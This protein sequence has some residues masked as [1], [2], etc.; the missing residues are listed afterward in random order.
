MNEKEKY[1]RFLRTLEFYKRQNEKSGIEDNRPVTGNVGQK[2]LGFLTDPNGVLI[3]ISQAPKTADDLGP[4]TYTP[5]KPDTFTKNITIS[6]NSKRMEFINRRMKVGPGDYVYGEKHTKMT[7]KISGKPPSPPVKTMLSGNIGQREWATTSSMPLPKNRFPQF[8]FN[9]TGNTRVFASR[10]ERALFKMPKDGVNERLSNQTQF[11]PQINYDEEV[12]LSAVFRSE[13]PRYSDPI[14]PTPAPTAYNIASTFGSSRS[15][16]LD[17][18][19]GEVDITP[20]PTPPGPGY[21]DP[22]KPVPPRSVSAHQVYTPK[23]LLPPR[24]SKVKVE[25]FE[26]PPPGSYDAEII[27]ERIPIAIRRKDLGGLPDWNQLVKPTE[28]RPDPSKYDVSNPLK[29]KGGLITVVGHQGIV[30][31]RVLTEQNHRLEFSTPHSSLLKRT[32][33]SKYSTP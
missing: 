18:L 9:T 14:L 32:Y 30:P 4:T 12:P 27:D 31:K 3:R 23:S 20:P 17:P 26:T 16:S 1:L 2:C 5:S 11:G 13:V 21:Y 8:K 7:H 29:G 33:N 25:K 28:T 15:T 24:K 22:D 19:W 10:D 6:D